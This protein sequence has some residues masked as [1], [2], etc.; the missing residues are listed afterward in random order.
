M[1]KPDPMFARYRVANTYQLA[2]KCLAT[3]LRK[4]LAR[5]LEERKVR[6]LVFQKMSCPAGLDRT[7]DQAGLE[8]FISLGSLGVGYGHVLQITDDNLFCFAHELAHTFEFDLSGEKVVYIRTPHDRQSGIEYDRSEQFCDT[9]AYLYLA[10]VRNRNAVR[11]YLEERVEILN[12]LAAAKA[13][14]DL[15]RFPEPPI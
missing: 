2:Q 10:H 1:K 12:Q 3:L 7:S 4:P 8:I 11:N 14:S 5:Q 13:K 15:Q 9:F 6:G